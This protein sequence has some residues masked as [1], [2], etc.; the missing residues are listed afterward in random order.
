MSNTSP[1]TIALITGTR[2]D[3]GLLRSIMR[4]SV[5]RSARR[6]D[7]GRQG[8]LGAE[9]LDGSRVSIPVVVVSFGQVS[10]VLGRQEHGGE[11]L[12]LVSTW[13]EERA[14]QVR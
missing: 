14:G 10:R 13:R 1:W 5:Q 6:R 11:A 9:L 4:A 7:G 3:Y 8:S 2:A 12:C